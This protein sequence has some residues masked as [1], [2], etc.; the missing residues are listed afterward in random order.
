M[1]LRHFQF[2]FA[3][4]DQ[5]NQKF[6]WKTKRLPIF[7]VLFLLIMFLFVP[8]LRLF[9]RSYNQ[10]HSAVFLWNN[11]PV[12]SQLTVTLNQSW[13][14]LSYLDETQTPRGLLVDIW[15]VIADKMGCSVKFIL[16]EHPETWRLVQEGKA[17]IY[18]SL[19]ITDAP[20]HHLD[21]T[22]EIISLDI[23]LFA[24]PDYYAL[25]L[26]HY[27][28]K[29]AGIARQTVD[30][31]YTE[32]DPNIPIVIY[33]DDETMVYEASQGN[34][35]AFISNYYVGMF[36]LD[37]YAEPGQYIPQELL[38]TLPL[39]AGIRKENIALKNRINEI[40]ADTDIL[41][42]QLM[43]QRWKRAETVETTPPWILAIVVGG[44]I[45]LLLS[46]FDLIL[47]RERGQLLKKISQHARDLEVSEAKYRQLFEKSPDAYFIY[48]N[49]VFTDCNEAALSLLAATRQQIIGQ[50]PE[51]IS[52]D[53]QPDGTTSE[54]GVKKH[55]EETR[56]KGKARFEWMHK[57]PNGSIFW[58]D[59][60]LALL[61]DQENEKLIVIFR[62]ITKRKQA[63]QNL[64]L[65]EQFLSSLIETQRE[66]IV[67]FLPDTTLT[68][69][70]QPY[71]RIYGLSEEELLGRKFIDL[72]PPDQRP[73][74][75][76]QLSKLN[77]DNPS[78]TFPPQKNII[79]GSI[80]WLEWTNNV[81][82][83]EQK[84][85][86]EYQATG[87]DI[88]E[89]KLAEEKLQENEK[90]LASI[91]ETQ[92]EM[93]CRFLPD[94]TLTF[95][96]TAYCREFGY[97]KE[98]L[99]GEKFL[100]FIPASYHKDILK[101]LS[102]LGADNPT[103]RYTHKSIKKDGTI[104]W[105]EWIDKVILDEHN[106]IV[107]F[108]SAGRDITEQKKAVD[109]LY[110]SEEKFRQITENMRDICWLRDEK[111]KKVLYINPA[112]EKIYG[113]SCQSLYD[114]PQSFIDSIYE[115]DKALFFE[116]FNKY[117]KDG[118]YDEL[119]YR[120]V[121]PDGEIRWIH[122][123][124][125]PV[126][127]A[128]G[129]IIR[130]A[131]IS[132]DIT[133]RKQ[134]EQ[135]LRFQLSFQNIATQTYNRFIKDKEDFD[136]A[137][138]KTLKS[139]GELL[140]VDRSYVFMFSDDMRF[141]SNTHEWCA[142]GVNSRQ[143]SLQNLSTD[144]FSWWKK[145]ILKQKVLLINDIEDLPPDAAAEKKEFMQENI[146][147]LVCLPINSSKGKTIG[148]FGFDSIHKTH[149]M[150]KTQISMLQIISDL[151]SGTIE[152]KN[153]QDNLKQNQKRY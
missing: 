17:D 48:E 100:K 90:I 50:G 99:I 149:L 148:F 130:H 138:Y 91:V 150:E 139:L 110:E 136:T 60:S 120:I 62:D 29:Q 70:N 114:N 37:R 127:D 43:A 44:A 76:E 67:R 72:L 124:S 42:K 97:R 28:G 73:S 45:I 40:L 133:E 13:P 9:P 122:S 2:F 96:N 31:E 82:L 109:A 113:K 131:G 89:Q 20:S 146:H 106:N 10:S 1:N 27:S 115:E 123:R 49:G 51:I 87:R 140:Q 81:I 104:V 25:S 88:T 84:R 85:V 24:A 142:P 64:R 69:V 128:D 118:E 23:Y 71:C 39:A 93:L 68:F 126:K 55:F 65:N 32:Y 129:K 108:Q 75:L 145:E 98:E 95:V 63:E 103:Q 57:R 111:K 52:P 107:E 53:Y 15:E 18:G 119:E 5:L 86:I 14:P 30:R 33:S 116:S 6:L 77:A 121:R 153:T 134:L 94:T 46:L 141:M 117:M 7:L 61:P 125:F 112:Y 56:K 8:I 59:V 92:Q 19:Y 36:L 83:D 137:I 105:H 22:D 26:L 135:N 143:S 35:E 147:S 74:I 78:Q 79:K 54:E 38:Y 101:K 12:Q 66:M 132:T 11:K 58:V 3:L 34:I 47:Y 4:R 41:D 21:Y 102:A 16:V 144:V 151:L 80:R 152:L